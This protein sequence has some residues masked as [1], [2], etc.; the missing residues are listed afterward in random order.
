MK[1]IQHEIYSDI[2]EISNGKLSVEAKQMTNKERGSQTNR[3][4]DK[5]KMRLLDNSYKQQQ[6][7]IQ[8]EKCKGIL[9]YII[10]KRIQYY[11]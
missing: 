11:I 10:F 6:Q 9:R 4:V 5:Y 8:T 7:I 3:Q 1:K 2:L